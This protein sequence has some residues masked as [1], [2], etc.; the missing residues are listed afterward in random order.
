MRGDAVFTPDTVNGYE[1]EFVD[2]YEL[3]FHSSFWQGR[4]QSE[5]RGVPLRLHRHA[6]HAGRSRP[7]SAASPASSTTPRRRRCRAPNSKAVCP[8]AD[9]LTRQFRA[10]ATS[11]ASSTSTVEHRRRQPGAAAGDASPAPIDL[12]NSAALPEHAGPDRCVLVHLH[13]TDLAAARSP[14]RRRPPIAATARCSSSPRR[15][16]ISTA[17]TLYNA[18]RHLDLRQR[19]LAAWPARTEPERRG[20]PRRRLQLPGRAV[21]QL[22]HRLLRPA[23]HGDGRRSKSGSNPPQD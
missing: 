23:A 6:D 21:R 5:R 12:S 10:W 9:S 11:T 20:V 16:S 4:A 8:S 18:S 22:D 14:S 2:T 3:G 13:G 7:P 19:S 1:P 15:C 17:Y